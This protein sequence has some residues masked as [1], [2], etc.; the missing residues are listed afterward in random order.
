[1][2]KAALDNLEHILACQ[3]CLEDFEE[4]GDKVPRILPCSH[5]VCQK[6]L[7]QLIRQKLVK[8]PECRL[9]HKAK[10]D[11]KSFPQNKYILAFVWSKTPSS[12]L[13]APT[14]KLKTPSSMLKTLSSKLKTPSSKLK[15]SSSHQKT[16]SS[17][18]NT[19][20]SQMNTTS[21]QMNTLSSRMKTENQNKCEEHGK[22]LG[23][24]CRENGCQKA[25]CQARMLKKHRLHNVIEIE[26]E[27]KYEENETLLN[28]VKE[29]CAKLTSCVQVVDGFVTSAERP[30]T[31]EMPRA[32]G[33]YLP[34]WYSRS[35]L[36]LNFGLS[37]ERPHLIKGLNLM[38][39]TVA[40]STDFHKNCGFPQ[41][42]QILKNSFQNLQKP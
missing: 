13:K 27:G 41:K 6:C 1:M 33:T 40:K 15:T 10:N 12:Q 8:C 23:L 30:L 7:A 5:T 32:T 11:V 29:L 9:K 26:E 19:T 28:D 36:R 21:S 14:S 25:I 31:M 2:A 35:W 37:F 18:M 16:T 38:I 4:T 17:Q 42:L 24:Y 34:H 39:P 20:S 22:E 3:I